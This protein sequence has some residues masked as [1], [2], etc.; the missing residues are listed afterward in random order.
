MGDGISEKFNSALSGSKPNDA[1]I[2]PVFCLES[3][4]RFSPTASFSMTMDSASTQPHTTCTASMRYTGNAVSNG[5]G[6]WVRYDDVL[7]LM[8]KVKN[9]IRE[10]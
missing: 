5:Y 10:R 7:D 3:L 4:K 2:D 9:K 8:I 1:E 6:A